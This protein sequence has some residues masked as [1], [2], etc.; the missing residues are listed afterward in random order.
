[1]EEFCNINM[2]FHIVL[3]FL[4]ISNAASQDASS[5]QPDSTPAPTSDMPSINYYI[6]HG[7][8]L[9]IAFGV[10]FPDGIMVSRSSQAIKSLLQQHMLQSEATTITCQWLLST[11]TQKRGCLKHS[12]LLSQDFCVLPEAFNKKLLGHKE[13][14]FS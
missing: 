8:L 4:V 14:K 13:E 2:L 1:M 12:T 7:F 3:I 9:W 5:P 10:L 6:A 11:W